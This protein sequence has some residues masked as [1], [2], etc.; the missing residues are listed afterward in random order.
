M[1]EQENPGNAGADRGPISKDP[2]ASMLLLRTIIQNALD[3]GYR[4]AAT[5]P[6]QRRSPLLRLLAF[7]AVVA[8]AF[9]TTAAARSLR[10]SVLSEDEAT[11]EMR[12]HV[13]SLE[14]TVSMLE[15][16]N[17]RL[18]ARI[19][20]LQTSSDP[21]G[22]TPFA[23]QLGAASDRV[24][25]PGVI[26]QITDRSMGA[27]GSRT[28][29]TDSDLRLVM[30]ILWQAGAE[31]MALNGK[32]VGPTTTVRTAGSAIL[33]NLTPVASPYVLE[34]VGDPGGLSDALEVGD[35]GREIS[36]LEAKS[37]IGLS[38][39]RSPMLS[40]PGLSVEHRVVLHPEQEKSEQAR[41]EQDEG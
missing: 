6:H 16:D 9:A 27:T 37:G 26:V 7:I 40:L 18:E 19:R 29:V 14:E 35:S 28:Q 31:A 24:S 20:G 13:E 5:K 33:V 30:N 21:G 8:L 2:A 25:G 34:V 41:S 38:V 39:T 12:E 3:P 36:E 1:D 10:G 4:E 17:S 32:R 22:G 15:T 23:L 11:S